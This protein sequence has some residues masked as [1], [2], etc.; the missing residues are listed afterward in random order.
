MNFLNEVEKNELTKFVENKTQFE[1]VR[2]VIL[3][4]VFYDGVLKQGEA[5]DVLRNF[6]IA[7][8]TN[9]QGMSPAPIGIDTDETL[10]RKLRAMIDGISMVETAFK[11]F[12]QFEQKVGEQQI[13]KKVGR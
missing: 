8:F 11:K 13:K 2:K 3:S 4:G 1:A 10:G 9:P 6:M 7:R 5:M 12:E